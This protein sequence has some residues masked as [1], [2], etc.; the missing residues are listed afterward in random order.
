MCHADRAATS[1]TM[2]HPITSVA[3][4]LGVGDSEQERIGVFGDRP[5]LLVL[6]EFF[7]DGPALFIL[8]FLLHGADQPNIILG[9]ALSGAAVN[10][11]LDTVQRPLLGNLKCLAVLFIRLQPV[12]M[13]GT[14]D[15]GSLFRFRHNPAQGERQQKRTLLLV[16][17]M[18][19]AVAGDFK[20]FWQD[21]HY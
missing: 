19:K 6:V 2:L 11:R 13:A 18:F 20:T 16:F 15:A 3:G 5:N 1:A 21:R 14:S 9:D 4:D 17:Q 10:L 12:A 7:F 8:V